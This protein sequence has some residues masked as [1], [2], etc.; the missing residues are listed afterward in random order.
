[1]PE[2]TPA[3]PA[4]APATPAAPVAASYAEIKAACTGADADFI[5]SQL[6]Q[7]A[8]ID[9]AR[10]AWMAEQSKRLTAKEAELAQAKAA[11][12]KPPA[13]G[14]APLGDAGAK[15]SD[16]AGDPLARWNELVDGYAKTTG[17][18]GKAISMAVRKHPEAHRDYLVAFNAERGRQ[19]D[20]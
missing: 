11:A 6:E 9:Q 14:V 13:P 8:T 1:M 20:R 16:D 17:D 7:S 12:A 4:S 2:P 5:C 19:I 15:K 18:R 10:N 3:T